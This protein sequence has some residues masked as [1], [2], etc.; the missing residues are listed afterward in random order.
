MAHE[1]KV[2]DEQPFIKASTF[3]SRK[4]FGFREVDV[5]LP[6]IEMAPWATWEPAY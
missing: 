6:R 2:A 4:V 1:E 5:Q 3:L